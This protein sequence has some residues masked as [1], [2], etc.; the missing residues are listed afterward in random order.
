MQCQ[1]PDFRYTRLLTLA[2]YCNVLRA[3]STASLLP[4]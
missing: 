4:C 2:A 3:V 1:I